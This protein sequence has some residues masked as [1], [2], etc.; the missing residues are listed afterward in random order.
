VTGPISEE[1]DLVGHEDAGYDLS[2]EGGPDHDDD[3][4][5]GGRHFRGES[6]QV[7]HRLPRWLTVLAIVVAVGL[8]VGGIGIFWVE[9][10]INPPGHP[11]TPVTVTIPI[12]ASTGT[13]ASVLGKAGVIKSPT[14]FRMYVKLKGAGPLLAG[15][16]DLP[17]H[18]SYDAVISVLEKGP[19][20]AASDV[21][22]T[23]PEGFTLAQISDRVGTLPGLS[24]RK[25][26]DLATNGQIR[27]PFE[28]ATVNTL[29]GLLYPATYQIGPSDTEATIIQ[30][31]V[32]AFD[33]AAA[34]IGLEPAAA[35]LGLTPY[36]VIV[37]ASMVEREAKLD[38]DRGPIASVIYNR[39]KKGILLQID[40]TVLYG[41]HITDPHQIDLKADNP[42][43][44]YRYKG[45]PPTPIASPGTPS[46][47]AAAS[48]PQTSY[49]Y[50][51][52]ISPSG[53]TG[54]ASTSAEFDK[55]KAQAKAQGLL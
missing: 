49:L 1:Y 50:Y 37:V 9:R 25:F 53:K 41:E 52:L 6:F 11:G 30:R 16:Y 27:S 35:Q 8:V 34:T 32:D 3:D 5:S 4:R 7:R 38:E 40:A 21:R 51:V 20:Q 48:P 55:L 2:D 17:V 33:Q 19:P 39:L 31:M 29:E 43:N 22:L 42:Y 45:L 23:I 18:S 15:H 13:I 26:L 46:L 54:F 24:A 44:T 12:G 10:Q 47:T 28:P 14:V 36:Q